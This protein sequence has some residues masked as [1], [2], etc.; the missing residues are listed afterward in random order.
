MLVF[1]ILLVLAITFPGPEIV[2]KSETKDGSK[3][4]VAFAGVQTEMVLFELSVLPG[5]QVP[6][7]QATLATLVQVTVISNKSSCV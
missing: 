7:P 3:G 1:V 5:T 6:L 4:T 2:L